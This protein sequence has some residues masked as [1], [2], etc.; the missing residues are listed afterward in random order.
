MKSKSFGATA[1][2]FA[3]V[4]V[5]MFF[6]FLL[7]AFVAL[8]GPSKWTFLLVG[9]LAALFLFLFDSERLIFLMGFLVFLVIGQLMYFARINQALWVPYGLAA[10]LFLRIPS[11]Y[12]VSP[13]LKSRLPFPLQFSLGI[14]FLVL[15]F[16][17]A[18]NMPPFLQVVVGG[19][20]LIMLWSVF[21]LLALFS[22]S[23]KKM[24]KM[25]SMLLLM[26]F[27]QV[28]FVL[29]Q[30]FVV[31]PTRSTAGGRRGVAW[32]AV[33]GSM[34]GDP[35]SGG[36]SGSMAF[37]LILGMVMAISLWRYKQ[38]R[39]RTVAA[40]WLAGFLCIGLAEVKVVVVLLP[41]GMAIL[42][43]QDLLKRPLRAVLGGAVILS[44]AIGILAVYSTMYSAGSKKPHDVSQLIDQAFGYSVDT[45]FIN[46][47]TGEMGRNAA[48]VFWWEQGFEPDPLRGLLGYGPG[49]SRSAST[50]AVGEIAAKYKFGIDRSTA[51]QL[52]WEVGLAGFLAY[53]FIIGG[54]ALT[55][56]R[57]VSSFAS[58]T[59]KAM[60]EATTAGLVMILVMLP[61]GRDVLE[62]PALTFTLMCMLGYA[63]QA[64]TLR[65]LAAKKSGYSRQISGA[66]STLLITDDDTIKLLK[67]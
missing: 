36:A 47:E 30:Y 39:L 57:S 61:Y 52:L 3:I 34:G 55:A 37:I 56:M 19:K 29:Y 17:I 23:F 33:V 41:I 62:V 14:F 4:M 6:T 15:F 18:I 21:L 10:L 9:A 2:R 35:D 11:A 67:I 7:A 66:G 1:G 58:S 46:F 45:H 65:Q 28:P 12:L 48:L 31:V 43:R 44:L 53:V 13:F 51:A 25:L 50:L 54:A 20:N 64:Q 60:L 22:I 63:A 24:E 38:I 5:A 40:I 49:A 8:A 26:V 32:D 16:S 59:S 42:Y 27:L